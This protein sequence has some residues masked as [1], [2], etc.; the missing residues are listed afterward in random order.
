MTR[1]PCGE[2]RDR[3]VVNGDD[4]KDGTKGSK[5]RQEQEKGVEVSLEEET[6]QKEKDVREP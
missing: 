6:G 1:E 5:K 2:W 4:G 3:R